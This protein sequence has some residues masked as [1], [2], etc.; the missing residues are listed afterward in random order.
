MWFTAGW[1]SGSFLEWS[2]WNHCR[3][4]VGRDPLAGQRQQKDTEKDN[5]VGP[6]DQHS[7]REQQQEGLAGRGCCGRDGYRRGRGSCSYSSHPLPG[8][9]SA[10]ARA[11]SPERSGRVGEQ[12]MLA[13]ALSYH[14]IQ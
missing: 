1:P 11:G 10:G 7:P 6:G 9:V 3:R 13:G 12:A 2:S 4:S 8:I 5:Y 14:A